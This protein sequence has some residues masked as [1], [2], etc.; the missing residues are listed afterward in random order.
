[1]A[2]EKEQP[3]DVDGHRCKA[4]SA[5]SPDP[6]PRGKF[7][8]GEGIEGEPPSD[9][10]R[11]IGL[12]SLR[13]SRRARCSVLMRV[14]VPVATPVSAGTAAPW[15]P[16]YEPEQE[17]PDDQDP[18]QPEE[19]EEAEAPVSGVVNPAVARRRGHDMTCRAGVVGAHPNDRRDCRRRQAPEPYE[20]SIHDG[21]LLVSL[22]SSYRTRVNDL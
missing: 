18:E 4:L 6:P 5:P 11:L 3:E 10:R 13:R 22:D 9:R 21:T 15:T 20:S 19:W 16:E 1:A 12:S 8:K 17:V 14:L 2:G 7:G